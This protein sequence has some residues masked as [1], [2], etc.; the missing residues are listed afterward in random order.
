MQ[1]VLGA[2][3][4]T[5]NETAFSLSCWGCCHGTAAHAVMGQREGEYDVLRVL[6]PTSPTCAHTAR[7]S[8]KLSIEFDEFIKL[9]K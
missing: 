7:N 4:Y 1:H 2:T 6:F 5:K 8:Y 3:M 9:D